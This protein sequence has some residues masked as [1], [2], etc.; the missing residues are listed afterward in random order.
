M[1]V[2]ED[3]RK[4]RRQET[5]KRR[6]ILLVL[7][8]LVVLLSRSTWGVFEKNR[9]AGDSRSEQLKQ[10][11]DLTKRRDELQAQ[12]DRLDTDRGLEEAL[13][14]S[15]PVAADG[16]GVVVVTEEV[17]KEEKEAAVLETKNPS[18]FQR[19]KNFFQRD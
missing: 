7:V 18:F 3:R 1:S 8:I 5:I 14:T 13:R 4:K 6:V 19:I 12:V 11:Q 17:S 9:R 10:L 16:E 15:F 2:K